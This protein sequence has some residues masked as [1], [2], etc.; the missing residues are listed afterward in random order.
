MQT[1]TQSLI[2]SIVNIVVGYLLAL[3]TQIV[4]FPLFGVAFS[5]S[6]NLQLG[7]IFTV[8]SLLRSYTLRRVFN[9]WHTE[10]V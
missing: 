1:K 7:A 10:K 6:A 4:A 3:A 2:E 9:R 8:V 5:L